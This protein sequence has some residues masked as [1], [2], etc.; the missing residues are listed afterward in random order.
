MSPNFFDK[1][2][3]IAQFGC[4]VHQRQAQPASSLKLRGG[5]VV[6]SRFDNAFAKLKLK[7]VTPVHT[8]A[9]DIRLRF[10]R[11]FESRFCAQV[12]SGGACE[13]RLPVDEICDALFTF[14]RQRKKHL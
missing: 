4:R 14:R 1:G 3:D 12:S 5:N 11:H 9:N 13:L 2:R 6:I 10:H 8:E 7:V